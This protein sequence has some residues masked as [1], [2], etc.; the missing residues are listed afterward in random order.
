MEGGHRREPVRGPAA[1]LSHDGARLE[2]ACRSVDEGYSG[3]SSSAR[4]RAAGDLVATGTVDRVYVYA[5]DRLARR[6]AYQVLL[7]DEFR[8]GGA[9]VVFLIRPIG[10]R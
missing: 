9:E 7:L 4:A 5:P 2:P 6:Y 3:A 8:R 1:R 10:V